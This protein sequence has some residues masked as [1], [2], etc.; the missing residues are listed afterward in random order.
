M[1]T[2]L[3]WLITGTSSGFGRALVAQVLAR[4]DR[5]IA[6]SRTVD[7]VRDLDGNSG[8]L[9]IM[10]LDV[11]AGMDVLKSKFKQAVEFWGRIDVLVNN[12]G[13]LHTG[14]LEEGGS[15]L[16]R[17]QFEANVFGLLDVT[18]A[19][20]P[21]FRG[22]GGGTIVVIGS[23]SA[24]KTDIIGIGPYASSKAA[25]RALADT[26]SVELAPFNIRVLLVEP[27]AFRT[28][29]IRLE[30]NSDS[31]TRLAAYDGTRETSVRF[32]ADR[33]GTQDGD[34]A[35]A[36]AAVVEVV[37]GEG[38]AAGK[39]WP[40]CL[41]LGEDADRDV[42]EKCRTMTTH[43]DEWADVVQMCSFDK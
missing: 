42:R 7:G 13:T 38:R 18:N 40:S 28:N 27:G 8:D 10:E 30:T 2:P 5:V 43:L 31:G 29:M 4:G 26:L 11:T 32:Y 24:W 39:P 36:M 41:V 9:R 17:K 15:A 3:V 23:R 12:A 21:H 35:K 33:H 34:P 25:V 16:L 22:L 20:V 6:T 37:K 14:I 1:T 19:C